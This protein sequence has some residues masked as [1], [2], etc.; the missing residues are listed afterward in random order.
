M[1]RPPTLESLGYVTPPLPYPIS[2]VVIH[3]PSQVSMQVPTK[4]PVS[5]SSH[6]VVCNSRVPCPPAPLTPHGPCSPLPL[7]VGG[8][9]VIGGLVSL[10]PA[11]PP[12]MLPILLLLSENFCRVATLST[13]T[14][15]TGDPRSESCS[16]RTCIKR[17]DWGSKHLYKEPA[18][19]QWST[20]A[21]C[22]L[23][24]DM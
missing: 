14:W 19:A 23:M 8:M 16:Q 15:P 4:L 24:S 2:L 9:I 22:S 3:P 18:A 17:T 10:P 6:P 21:G 12:T 1:K 7:R 20:C 13:T 5:R 11:P